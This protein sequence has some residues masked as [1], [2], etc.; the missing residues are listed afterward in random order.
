MKKRLLTFN[1]VLISIALSCNTLY[2]SMEPSSKV[3]EVPPEETQISSHHQPQYLLRMIQHHLVS[4]PYLKVSQQMAP[5]CF[6][7]T[8]PD[9][10][11]PTQTAA[12]SPI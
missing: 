8:V 2:P 7:K 1:V 12:H 6:I 4:I 3:S 10:G 5:G 9:C 11:L